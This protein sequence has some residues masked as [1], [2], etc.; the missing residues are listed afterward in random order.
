MRWTRIFIFAIPILAIAA[1]TMRP[2]SPSDLA[3]AALIERAFAP[4]WS[5]NEQV[6]SSME[7]AVSSRLA[8]C[9][10][11]RCERLVLPREISS[12]PVWTSSAMLFT[13]ETTPAR[14]PR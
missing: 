3:A 2:H 1:Y 11:V 12:A 5:S 4:S 9:S 10:S 14:L 13:C 6:I 8:A 7:E